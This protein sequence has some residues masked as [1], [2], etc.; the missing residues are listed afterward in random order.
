M[1][2]QLCSWT[3]ARG[4]GIGGDERARFGL[5]VVSVTERSENFAIV[6]AS[7]FS[8]LFL[9]SRNQNPGEDSITVCASEG[10]Y[11]CGD[12]VADAV[13]RLGSTEQRSWEV[14]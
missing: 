5:T 7:N 12:C 1:P 10:E 14:I 3:G 2:V 13:N 9:L 11:A 8:T 6:Q 4:S